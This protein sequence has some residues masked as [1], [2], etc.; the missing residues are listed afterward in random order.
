[1]N[2]KKYLL[3]LLSS[4]LGFSCH[5]SATAGSWSSEEVIGG[6]LETF[7]YT[8]ATDPALNG[9]R[10][11]MINL[12]GCIQDNEDLVEAGNW[13]TV[14]DRYGMV[15]ALPQAEG[16]GLLGLMGCWDF[17]SGTRAN[18]NSSDQKYLLDLVQALL[19][20]PELNI[21]PAQVYLTGLSSGAGIANQMWCL[22]PEVFAGVGVVAGPAPGS[23][24]ERGD[25]KKP[26]VSVEQG[27]KNCEQFTPTKRRNALRTQLWNTA[28]GS[29]DQLVSPLHARRNAEIAA[30]VYGH[31]QSVSECGRQAFEAGAKKVEA[32]FWCDADGQR[33]SALKLEGMAHAWPSGGKDGFFIDGGH[34]NYPAWITEWFFANNRRVASGTTL[35]EQTEN[36]SDQ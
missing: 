10:A 29:E 30:A 27:R 23:A 14:A 15:V 9:K 26:A 33:I 24:G 2:P 12:H 18:R 28:H 8:P 17:H 19:G 32:N 6:T 5:L 7:V 13:E 11:L 21:D 34:L 31:Q 22:A 25:L 20:K 16:A 4:V 35:S 1:M 3:L 36:R